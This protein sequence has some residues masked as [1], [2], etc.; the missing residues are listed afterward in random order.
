MAKHL[1]E[2]KYDRKLLFAII[3]LPFNVYVME[4]HDQN[5]AKY[6]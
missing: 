6:V 2:T 4:N 3:I 1:T 5:H